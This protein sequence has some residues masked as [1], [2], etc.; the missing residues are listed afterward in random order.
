MTNT[1]RVIAVLLLIVFSRLEAVSFA[2]GKELL[3]NCSS[4]LP[5][6]LSFCNGMLAGMAEAHD[7]Y[8]RWYGMQT[9]WCT[10]AGVTTSQLR[11]IVT[12][13]LREHQAELYLE[14]GALVANAY[15]EAFPCSP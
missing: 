4:K 12:A 7:L 14:A 13:Y 9:A 11:E 5:T 10:P 1:R 8:T 15:V 6:D 2:T 3:K